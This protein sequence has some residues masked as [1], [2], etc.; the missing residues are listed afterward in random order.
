MKA[1]SKLTLATAITVASASLAFAQQADQGGHPAA[2]SQVVQ[3]SADSSH[4]SNGVAGRTAEGDVKK[5]DKEAGKITIRHEELKNLG[6]PAMT[7]VFRAKDAAMLDQIKQGDK[8]SFVA[9]KV[10][11]QFTVTQIEVKQ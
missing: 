10:D 4:K 2:Y 11:G 5:V 1:L 8:V 3:S 6:M 7:M 9:D